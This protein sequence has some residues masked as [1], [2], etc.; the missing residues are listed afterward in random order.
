[1]RTPRQIYLEVARMIAEEEY[2]GEPWSCCFIGNV[3]DLGFNSL[4][5]PLAQRYCEVFNPE[6][7]SYNFAVQVERIP[8][9]RRDNFRVL[10]LTLMAACWKDFR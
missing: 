3:E 6:G 5:S 1:M 9:K 8:E 2:L 4:D 10:M 7:D